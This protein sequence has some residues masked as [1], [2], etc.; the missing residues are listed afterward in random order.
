MSTAQIDAIAL[1]QAAALGDANPSLIQ[2]AEATRQAANLAAG[3]DIVPGSDPSILIAERGTFTAPNA[4]RPAGAPA[5]NGTVF[6][7]VV[8]IATGQVTDTGITDDYPNLAS[9]GTVTT[10]STSTTESAD[11]RHSLRRAQRIR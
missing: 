5:P 1:T 2:H 9:L 7:M 11:L 10:D 4:P 8:D 6:T 3:G